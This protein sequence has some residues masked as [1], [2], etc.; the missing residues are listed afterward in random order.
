MDASRAT[1][2]TGPG[3]PGLD[4][5]QWP[6]PTDWQRFE[7]LCHSLWRRIW[8]DPNAQ[9]H[10]RPGQQQQGVDVYG[11]PKGARGI[12]G[13]QCKRKDVLLA[14]LLTEDEV[15]TEVENAKA[16]RPPLAE[17]IIATCA[18]SDAGLQRLARSITEDHVEQ[19]LF[20]VHVFGWPEIVARMAEH[21]EV[22]AQ[23]YGLKPIGESTTEH[24]SEKRTEAR[25]VEVL[26]GQAELKQQ[27]AQLAA[28]LGSPT[29]GPAH[30]KLDLCR[31]LL[32]A[33]SY[34]A[35]LTS[36]ERIYEQE[37]EGAN[38]ALRF[39]IA[40]NLGAAHLGMGETNKG[41]E[42][43]LQAFDWDKTSD[44]AYG[45][46]AIALYLLGR[47]QEAL[48]AAQA[49][50]EK[51]PASARTWVA[52]L[53]IVPRVDSQA[54]IPEIPELVAED[55]SVLFVRGDVF[56]MRELWEEAEATLRK[57]IA[58]PKSDA[59]AKSRLAEVILAQTAGSRFY[60]G[61]Q[62]S[63]AEMARLVEA[64]T[65][66]NETWNEI[67][68][69][70]LAPVSLHVVQNLCAIGAVLGDMQLAEGSIDEALMLRPDEPA[71]LSWKIRMLVTRGDGTAATRLLAKLPADSAD[72][73]PLIA[74]AAWRAAGDVDRAATTLERFIHASPD[75]EVA[76]DAR[77][78][79]ADFVCHADLAKATSRF[80]ALPNS[81]AVKVARSTVIFARALRDTGNESDGVRYLEIAREQLSKST[82]ARDR[83]M[84]A[85]ALAEFEDCK[86]AAA[87]YEQDLTATAD[88]PSLRE[89]CRC[90]FELDQRQRLT[91]LLAALPDHIA[92]KPWYE[93][94]R[95]RLAM[96]A[97]DLACARSALE[98]CLALAPEQFTTRLSWAEACVRIDD[99][100]PAADWLATV[101]VRSTS[102]SM[103]QLMRLGPLFHAVGKVE[104]AAEA[105]YEALRRFSFDPRTHLGFC[106]SVLF[107]GSTT[108]NRN[109]ER[110]GARNMAIRLRQSDGQERVYILEDRP[111][112]ELSGEEIAIDSE[113]GKRLLGRKVGD[114]VVGHTSEFATHE[115]TVISI[116][117]KYV[118]ALDL[119][120]AA[121]N[122]RFPDSPGL[123]GMKMPTTG[124]A[125][126]QLK[127]ILNAIKERA[128]RAK[129][130]VATN[131]K[132]MP[133][134][135]V[136]TLM[137][138]AAIEAWR[139]LIANSPEPIPVC[140]GNME[141]R[142]AA[143]NLVSD[144][145]QRVILEPIALFELDRLN[146]L[147][148]VESVCGRLALTQSTLDEI[149]GLLRDL[150]L[151][152]QGYMTTFEKDGQYFRHEV[153]ARQVA[154]ERDRLQSLFSWA[155]KHCEVVA[156]IPAKDPA[157]EV[158]DGLHRALG[159]ATFDTLLAAQGGKFVLLTD[160]WNL[161]RLAKGEFQ[162]DGVWVQPVL[163][164]AAET[165]RMKRDH[166]NRSVS[167]L[168]SWRHQFTSID[169]SQLLFAANRGGWKVTPEFE[170]LVAS[171]PLKY[172]DVDS[173]LRVV[174][175]FLRELWRK[176]R[177]PRRSQATKL[178]HALL[179]GMS[180]RESTNNTLF[181]HTLHQC[182]S[183]GL[184]P[185]EAWNA[186]RSWY[187]SN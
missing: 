99:L 92:K 154:E 84:L 120:L 80:D 55:P 129:Q 183:R 121:F 44:K 164:H 76:N 21:G 170:A 177:G 69:T 160:D 88:N 182:A 85:D 15:R 86:S 27:I 95:A 181:F 87:I 186:C 138:C 159:A 24:G 143:F 9:L 41:A 45:N 36:L 134:A 176:G 122:T 115:S 74:A 144:R 111:E 94:V 43:L 3:V 7:R 29:D 163:M 17:L 82:D 103:E 136:G 89:Y 51:F 66:L 14:T 70:E 56:A 91:S 102:L 11:N 32:E 147:T 98:R 12:H 97:G 31:E 108:W 135:G 104:E 90:L 130:V 139:G 4:A 53:N 48:A 60:A 100:K 148:V 145:K 26:S 172:S 119:S 77:C 113:L 96:R 146:S 175:A 132:G 174:V 19:G 162:L 20:R 83:L 116:Q 150:D 34:R 106:A 78:M 46:Y 158:A 62:Y 178:T 151:H 37:W 133:I 141:E 28:T 2:P 187:E 169:H 125:E 42:F 180:P 165:G 101:D 58:L 35:A 184:L 47:Q 153:S 22:I 16:F 10:G 5:Y 52:Y 149:R 64:R 124:T 110:L 107:K 171:F 173:S 114:V 71:L 13:I 33:H 49:A 140:A 8:D 61:A 127:P 73:Y 185:I 79:F 81:G 93:S 40:T 54:A 157:P 156:A 161:R 168:A 1:S 105:F 30:A 39:R 109:L 126:E 155:V 65:L 68:R 152:S 18:P 75:S 6:P 57:L 25:H 112:G 179:T 38:N 63:E 128:N 23:F 167:T 50:V 72:E 131:R 137:G 67:K 117:H 142:I 123:I 166:Y 59:M 118:H